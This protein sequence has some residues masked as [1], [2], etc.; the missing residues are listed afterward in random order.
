MEMKAVTASY[1]DTYKEMQKK[2][3]LSEIRPTPFFSK[4]CLPSIIQSALFSHPDNLQPGT[5]QSFQQI[6]TQIFHVYHLHSNIFCVKD[7]PDP[8]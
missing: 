1:T 3:K 7:S 5:P 8:I 6:L 4:T 2:A